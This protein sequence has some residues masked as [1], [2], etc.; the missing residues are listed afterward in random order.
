[1]PTLAEGNAIPITEITTDFDNQPRDP[2]SPDI[3]ADEGDFTTIP[4]PPTPP[5]YISPTDLSTGT[6]I[7]QSLIWNAGPGGGSPAS[8]NIYIGTSIPLPSIPIA[9]TSENTYDPELDYETTYYWKIV[10]TN[11]SGSAAGPIWSFTTEADTRITS[12]PHSQNFDTVSPPNLPPGWSQ[13]FANG[14][15]I[16]TS[17]AHYDT[18][19]NSVILSLTSDD[20]SET[21]PLISPQITVG[22]ENI[23]MYFRT[24]WIGN[25][26]S[27]I[28]GTMT[29]PSNESTFTAFS[30]ISLSSDYMLFNVDFSGYTG[31]DQYLAFKLTT[32]Y[33]SASISLD[34]I[35]LQQT[36]LEN[37]LAVLYMTGWT[38][39]FP[40][41]TNTQSVTIE[42]R[43]TLTQS[44]YIIRLRSAE[45]PTVLSSLNVSVPI[46]PGQTGVF[47]ISWT[48]PQE[49]A[50]DIYGEVVLTGDEDD[51]NNT[52]T[53]RQINIYGFDTYGVIVG[54]EEGESMNNY[55]PFAFS[56]RNSISETI[57][58]STEMQMQSGM[59]EG[60]IYQS[61]FAEYLIETPI[62][63]WIKNTD[64]TDLSAGWLD[65]TGYT[66][67]FDGLIN[68]ENGAYNS[69]HIP[70]SAPFAYTG[71]NLAIRAVR[72]MDTQ[73][74]MELNS[75]H[76]TMPVYVENRSRYL[77]SN[78]EF[79]D[80]A[81][82]FDSGFLTS[83]IPVT[84]FIAPVATPVVLT[85]PD[86]TIEYD[87]TD[88]N[89]SWTEIPG[90]YCYRVFISDN[91]NYW[92]EV[93]DAVI[94]TNHYTW[95]S[96]F[97]ETKYFRVV[98]VSSYR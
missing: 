92:Q 70:L 35:L 61:N 90:A 25:P 42:N 37:D 87:G 7:T 80:P 32:Y 14:S 48:P 26:S 89:L 51:T 17:T 71:G 78:A 85:A 76:H 9:S 8:Y 53:T 40:G 56:F 57:Y 12:L 68:I 94:Y 97:E 45:G 58:T 22:I 10:A 1:V 83:N 72:P 46:E 96:P 47:P 93:P 39:G 65:F 50:Y 23:R 33:P 52:S 84:Y 95:L 59:I 82:P 77:T 49:G 29:D 16:Q 73:S 24:K 36:Q 43:G 19:P 60:I 69:V 64:V 11:Y 44:S 28:V 4:E 75:F 2:L 27:I 91:P 66:L 74:Y 13:L 55:L 3:G 5:V 18:A 79:I 86:V 81:N 54:E 38:L 98:A 30:T 63:L 34:T 88:I 20:T 41:W 21:P 6:S 15:S 67:V 31:S 62:K